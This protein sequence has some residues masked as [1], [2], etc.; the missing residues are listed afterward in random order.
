MQLKND[1]QSNTQQTAIEREF[2]AEANYVYKSHKKV[3][4]LVRPNQYFATRHK[5]VTA[6]GMRI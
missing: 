3:I 4:K 1:K 6:G 2:G 5:S